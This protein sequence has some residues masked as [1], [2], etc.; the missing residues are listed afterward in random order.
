[1]P[2]AESSGRVGLTA[3]YSDECVLF[4]GDE[5]GMLLISRRNVN[6]VK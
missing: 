4:F 1:L 6:T 3:G 2:L 5:V